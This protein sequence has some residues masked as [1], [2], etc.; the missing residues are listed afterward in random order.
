ML[1]AVS[2]FLIIPMSSTPFFLPAVMEE[3][4]TGP[5]SN[6]YSTIPYLA[7]V[8]ILQI[9]AWHSDKKQE[10]PL[11]IIGLW[12]HINDKRCSCILNSYVRSWHIWI[13]ISFTCIR[14]LLEY[15]GALSGTG[16][17]YWWPVGCNDTFR[18]LD[19]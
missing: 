10:R 14:I 9:N 6:L 5:M 11:H 19:F 13:F 1:G 18:G 3:F 12:Y 17:C 8:V 16:N 4:G 2:F 7:A 15:L